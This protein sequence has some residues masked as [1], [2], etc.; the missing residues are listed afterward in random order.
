MLM[1]APR[2][3]GFEGYSGG[4]STSCVAWE[5]GFGPFH[6]PTPP[7]APLPRKKKK[8]LECYYTLVSFWISLQVPSQALYW[9]EKQWQWSYFMIPNKVNASDS[10]E[11]YI[12]NG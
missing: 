4:S 12:R 7:P 3:L 6:T 5:L 1:Y 2:V 8:H 11:V 9:H 10:H